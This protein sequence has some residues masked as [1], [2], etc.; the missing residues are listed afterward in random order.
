ME[1]PG[2]CILSIQSGTDPIKGVFRPETIL[3]EEIMVQCRSILVADD[4]DDIREAIVE[5]LVN[6]G[7]EVAS[8]R[9]GREALERLADLPAPTLVLLDLMMPVMS[10]WEFLDAQKEDLR[11]AS[12]PVVTISAVNPNQSIEDPAPLSTA[13]AIQKPFSLG[14]LWEKVSEFCGPP[15]A[16]ELK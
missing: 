13:G 16:F 12:H 11:F 2:G 10:G 1:W 9:D 7:Y 4:N 5:A 8:A 6:E 14:K 3:N 15:P